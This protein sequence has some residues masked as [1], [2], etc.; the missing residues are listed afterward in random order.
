MC[1]R[2]TAILT[3]RQRS[4]W[5]LSGLAHRQITPYPSPDNANRQ[6]QDYCTVHALSDRGADDNEDDLEAGENI[7]TTALHDAI[8]YS[9]NATAEAT[10]STLNTLGKILSR[11]S[12]IS[13]VNAHDSV[14]YT[15]L[16]WAA[17]FNNA[18][19]IRLLLNHGADIRAQDISGN[20]P[21]FVALLH[22]YADCATL[23]MKH[24]DPSST[25]VDD[26]T[27]MG[28]RRGIA[29]LF[30][31]ARNADIPFDLMVTLLVRLGKDSLKAKTTAEGWSVIHFM[32]LAAGASGFQNPEQI[33][34]MKRK[35]ELICGA[36]VLSVD[37]RD[38]KGQSPLMLVLRQYDDPVIVKVLLNCGADVTLS[39]IKGGTVLHYLARYATGRTMDVFLEDL[40]QSEPIGGRRME[41]KR[42]WLGGMK[43]DMVACIAASNESE[44]EYEKHGRTPEEYFKERRRGSTH[45]GLGR[46]GVTTTRPVTENDVA[47][48][49]R[50]LRRIREDAGKDIGDI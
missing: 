42:L 28:N 12:T 11:P 22:G 30:P 27:N 3:M 45:E 44:E 38:N 31:A 14:G 23:L 39:D 26:W 1:K 50:L 41:G 32:V 17:Y 24:L 13:I 19:A 37:G 49:E 5:V 48:F 8:I 4:P 7:K 20:T 33:S 15:P 2:Q 21:L 10:E 43:P 25:A 18:A 35:M 6:L 16:H 47:S 29:P 36:G 34:L 9:V 40:E 46:D